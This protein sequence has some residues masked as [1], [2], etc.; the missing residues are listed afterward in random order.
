MSAQS[1][2][3]ADLVRHRELNA[4]RRL[5]VGRQTPA[6]SIKPTLL[7]EQ[8]SPHTAS[9]ALSTINELEAQMSQT[10]F[11]RSVRAIESSK[12]SFLPTQIVV[13]LHTLVVADGA[14]APEQ[15]TLTQAADWFAANRMSEVQA[16]LT[17]ALGAQGNLHDHV[18]TWLTLFDFYRAVGQ[19]QLFDRTALD[20][21][22]RFGRSTPSWISFPALAEQAK[23]QSKLLSPS[24][25][26]R[27]AVSQRIAC[28]WTAPPYLTDGA[29]AGC[30]VLIH[31]AAM[32]KRSLHLDWR[33]LVAVDP[34]QWLTIKNQ[35]SAI[36]SQ[37]LRCV[38]YGMSSLTQLFSRDLPEAMLAYLAL[39]RCQNQAQAF[40]ELAMDYCTAFEISPPDWVPP[41]CQ[42]ELQDSP[43]TAAS[44]AAAPTPAS[45]M[46][47]ATQLPSELIGEVERLP[48]DWSALNFASNAA[49]L[50]A[51]RWVIHCDKLIRVAPQAVRDLIALVKVLAKNGIRVEFKD[52]HRLIAAYF[53]AQGLYELAK[54]SIRKD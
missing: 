15:V 42:I 29:F 53:L 36:A 31:N 6:P 9:H 26:S 44:L 14:A 47:N 49:P 45:A 19:A 37:N 5:M 33:G 3:H 4:L 51:E 40:E 28:D 23:L 16:L 21:S 39:L 22:I 1:K 12:T 2:Q 32:Q 25:T 38:M 34:A 8:Q 43:L 48:A 27:G 10:L 35:L 13:N 20:F 17:H 11:E 54:I 50:P 18:P 30:D 46:A 52:V 41:V 24:L 7:A